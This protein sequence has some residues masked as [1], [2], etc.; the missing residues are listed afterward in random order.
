MDELEELY[1]GVFTGGRGD[2]YFE[3]PSAERR[4]KAV[5]ITASAGE[6]E[7]TDYQELELAEDDLVDYMALPSPEDQTSKPPP[8]LKLIGIE[9]RSGPG[10]MIIDSDTFKGLLSAAS[11]SIE[12]LWALM[13]SS[14]GFHSMRRLEDTDAHVARHTWYTMAW[15]FNRH[16]LCSKV[17]W[18]DATRGEA[19][20][21]FMDLLRRFQKYIS[22]PLLVGYLYYL[23]T[24]MI[25]LANR[26]LYR[27]IEQSIG[28]DMYK[29]ETRPARPSR[30]D[31]SELTHHISLIHHQFDLVGYHQHTLNNSIQIINDLNAQAHAASLEE[32]DANPTKQ[33]MNS[34]SLQ[35]SQAFPAV[36]SRLMAQSTQLQRY[37]QRGVELCNLLFVLLTHEDAL[38]GADLAKLGAEIAAASKRDSASMKT[39]AVLTM[40]FLPATFFAA[41]FAIPSLDWKGAADSGGPVIQSNFWVYWAFTLPATV[42]VFVI[43]L[44]LNNRARL[45]GMYREKVLG[46]YK[47][48]VLG[49][50]LRGES[51]EHSSANDTGSG[52][53]YDGS[54]GSGSGMR[55]GES[56]ESVRAR[57]A[58]AGSVPAGPV[59]A[60]AWQHSAPAMTV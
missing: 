37:K 11:I 60:M 55:T 45:M 57:S 15:S 9:R 14:G 52:Y 19:Y 8:R 56:L 39:V 26:V 7:G 44:I 42:L 54:S 31:L 47:E 49:K 27:D 16:S 32:V 2:Y 48:R 21:S 18:I 3:K 59:G 34:S 1:L 36:R 6:V 13:E 51:E 23:S 12:G 28:Y 53:F 58:R 30:L 41:L 5:T 50:K 25:D 43:W 29:N 40:A 33:K 17:I 35:L 22:S 10:S 38:K 46:S 20:R 4:Y 24:T